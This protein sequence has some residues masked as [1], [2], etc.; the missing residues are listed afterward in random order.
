MRDDLETSPSGI[1]DYKLLPDRALTAPT[2]KCSTPIGTQ[3]E[4]P[5]FAPRQEIFCFD[6]HL[7]FQ[8][9]LWSDFMML[10]VGAVQIK[11]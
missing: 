8:L 1:E 2:T 4:V 3:R 5:A 11:D 10:V 9:S 7:P 6:N